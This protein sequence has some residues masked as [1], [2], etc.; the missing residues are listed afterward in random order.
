M[1][2][3]IVLLSAGSL[4][5][6]PALA[7]RGSMNETPIMFDEVPVAPKETFIARVRV[8]EYTMRDGEGV[9]AVEP[10]FVLSDHVKPK[11]LLLSYYIV[12]SCDRRPQ[13]GE[14]GLIAGKVLSQTDDEIRLYPYRAPSE[15]RLN[16]IRREGGRIEVRDQ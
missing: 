6:T 11:R 5:T 16:V 4:V 8:L 2:R 1:K 12:S 3:L 15:Y 14:E 10:L 7:C 9:I 13:I